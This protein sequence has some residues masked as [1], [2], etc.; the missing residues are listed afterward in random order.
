MA[1]EWKMCD[2]IPRGMPYTCHSSLAAAL[3]ALKR[4]HLQ[5]GR[6]RWVRTAPG[7]VSRGNL[8]R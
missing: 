4:G 7:K 5:F 3:T 1:C 2:S 8:Y 6:H